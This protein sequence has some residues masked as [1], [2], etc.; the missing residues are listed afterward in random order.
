MSNPVLEPLP[1]REKI[2][3]AFLRQVLLDEMMAVL[4]CDVSDLSP[5]ISLHPVKG[6]PNWAASIGTVH[7]TVLSAYNEALGNV[8]D[9][10]N[11]DDAAREQVGGH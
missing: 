5:R 6:E 7:L 2:S 11:L 4:G 9:R 1:P 10:Y 3:A 8:R